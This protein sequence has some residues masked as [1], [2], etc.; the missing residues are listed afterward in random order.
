MVPGRRRLLIL[1]CIKCLIGIT[2]LA[3]CGTEA[4]DNPESKPAKRDTTVTI[5]N[6]F[7]NN[8]LDSA[9]VEQFLADAGVRKEDS[10]AI[11]S[12]Y[13]GRNYEFAWFDSAGLTQ[14]ATSFIS[15]YRN[16]RSLSQDNGFQNSS[17]DARL[18]SLMDD[19]LYL[20]KHKTS[21]PQ[22]ELALT[23]QFFNYSRKAYAGNASL[24]PE[25]IGWFIPKKKLNIKDFLD[26]V[27]V[28][29]NKKIS[30]FEPVHPMFSPLHAYLE[31]YTAIEKNNGWPVID[32]SKPQYREGDDAP[33]IA[34]VKKRLQLVEDLP[35][36][37]TGS[38][39]TDATKNGV[40]NFQHRYGFKEDGII[41]KKLMAELNMPV[42]GRI[43]Q[44]MVN[45]E[46]IKWIPKP[47]TGRYIVVNIP[48]FKL[49]AFDS[50]KLAFSMNVVV[51]SQAHNTVIFSDV[52]QI[53]AFSPYWNVPY[54]IVK[55]EMSGKP[56]AYFSRNNY[57]ITGHYADGRPQVRQKPGPRNALGGVK[58]LFPNSYSIY[59][60]DT[61]SKGLFGNNYRAASH[62]CIRL[63]DPVKMATW[64]LDY[65][66]NWTRD[67]I[68]KSM[69]LSAE[70]QVRL[71]RTVPVFIGYFTAWVDAQ[72]K[73]NLRDDVYGHDKKMIS[74]LFAAN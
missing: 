3:G 38:L 39:F 21:I 31:K 14:H 2:L 16:Y 45:I 4:A 63:S 33:E 30:D 17:F 13:K 6:A 50:G 20:V 22:T 67:S 54:S 26:S 35:L 59:M 51:G 60:H 32:F 74:A 57:E 1:N 68:D 49:Y 29:K 61:P 65:D 56:A 44:L 18:D 69:H 52:V 27:I 12:F 40:I 48:A 36:T 62:G 66:P 25:D 28:N 15:L 58:F 47:G 11:I 5:T 71:K 64:L 73:L 8:F 53:V 42:T 7:N 55:N 10:A 46:R 19:S 72:G 43:K 23:G 37:D 70:M 34:L 9:A 24:N 41:N